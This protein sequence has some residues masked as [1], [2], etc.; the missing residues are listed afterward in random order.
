MTKHAGFTV[1]TRERIPAGT[2]VDEFVG[3]HLNTEEKG[4]ERKTISYAFRMKCQVPG[5]DI[6]VD[7][8]YLGN[9][10]RFFNH[11]CESNLAPFRFY[12]VHRRKLHPHLGFYASRDIEKNEELTIH[13]GW[14][15][16]ID[17]FQKGYVSCC[18]CGTPKCVLPNTHTEE[19]LKKDLE[20]LKRE[21]H[22][23]Q[24]RMVKRKAATGNKAVKSKR[25]RHD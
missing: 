19:E 20:K 5:R 9:V 21:F 7:P 17:A 6:I 15:W 23:V 1:I 22:G 11:S 2:Y 24:Q 10:T 13:Y 8:Y 4:E 25:S 14:D 18:Q 3:E 16:W 12:K